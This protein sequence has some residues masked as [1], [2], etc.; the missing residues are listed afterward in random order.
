MSDITFMRGY[1]FPRGTQM[2]YAG[3]SGFN[4]L[5][6]ANQPRRS[7]GA[8]SKVPF[9][10]EPSIFEKIPALDGFAEDNSRVF[11]PLGDD[12]TYGPEYDPYALEHPV[13]GP[14]YRPELLNPP[15]STGAKVGLGLLALALFGVL[16]R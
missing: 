3:Y 11:L 8:H 1:G 9:V 7:M 13:Q 14:E 4:G 15:M 12:P 6:V 2:D 10:P 5:L 16:S